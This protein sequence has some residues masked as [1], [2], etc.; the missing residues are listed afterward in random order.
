MTKQS[1]VTSFDLTLYAALVCISIFGL[2]TS[3]NASE[4]VLR[5]VL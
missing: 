4:M 3:N 1:L 2:F 5:T